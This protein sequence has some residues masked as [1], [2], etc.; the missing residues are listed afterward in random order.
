MG[1]H[2]RDSRWG[3]DEDRRDRDGADR[4]RRDGRRDD[5]DGGD[6]V[7]SRLQSMADGGAGPVSLLDMPDIPR[8]EDMPG[9][10]EDSARSEGGEHN[11][12][13]EKERD[14]AEGTPGS[15]FPP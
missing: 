6:D 9:Q 7:S 13:T 10:K 1:G 8:P 14:G 12:E 11:K 5:R 15:S 4:N 3:R 2:R